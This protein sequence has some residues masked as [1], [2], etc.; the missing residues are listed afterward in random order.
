[1]R[2][3]GSKK[4][5]AP[6]PEVEGR[7]KGGAI[8]GLGWLEVE[9]KGLGMSVAEAGLRLGVA[10]V[11]AGS[12]RLYGHRCHLPQGEKEDVTDSW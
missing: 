11:G 5:R 10:V 9:G 1:M 3:R 6:W 12:K 7:R 8:D 4:I 2:G